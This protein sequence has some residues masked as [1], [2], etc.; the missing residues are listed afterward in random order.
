MTLP[1]AH[2]HGQVSLSAATV[3]AGTAVLCV[4]TETDVFH[5]HTQMY[6]YTV[7]NCRHDDGCMRHGKLSST[8]ALTRQKGASSRRPLDMTLRRRHGGAPRRA[9]GG[10]SEAMTAPPPAARQPADPVSPL[11]VSAAHRRRES[12]VPRRASRRTSR[13]SRASRAE[14]RLSV[15]A[16]PIEPTERTGGES[17]RPAVMDANQSRDGVLAVSTEGKWFLQTRKRFPD[18]RGKDVIGSR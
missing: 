10:V 1:F 9:D 5:C 6:G 14:C 17:G 2:W 11:S 16:L 15:R 4:R 8:T 7:T 12:D 18:D 3:R 13:A